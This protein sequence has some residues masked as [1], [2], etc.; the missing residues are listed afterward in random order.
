MKAQNSRGRAKVRLTVKLDVEWDADLIG[1]LES[2]VPG[3]RSAL[4]REMLRAGLKQPARWE[5]VDI[6]EMRR[7]VAEELARA[8]AG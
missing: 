1:W 7:V 4:I 6:D 5:P 2:V 8:L 3:N